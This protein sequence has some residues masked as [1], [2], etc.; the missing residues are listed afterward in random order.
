MVC[1][2]VENFPNPSAPGASFLLSAEGSTLITDKEKI[3]ERWAEHFNSVLNRLSA[4]NN[5]AIDRLPP[6]PI[7]ETL[8]ALPTLEETQ[9]TA[10]IQWQSTWLRR[11]SS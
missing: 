7:D 10:T 6:V 5:D 2:T 4:I 9:I 8:D 1:I 3:L 11:H